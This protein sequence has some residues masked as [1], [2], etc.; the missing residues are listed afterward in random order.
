MTI[1]PILSADY[2][3]PYSRWCLSELSPVC[4]VVGGVLAQE[5]IKALSAKDRPYT[6]SFLY[7]GQRGT[8]IIELLRP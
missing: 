7:D 4:A 1:F 6:N 5:V 8:G 2:P 3:L